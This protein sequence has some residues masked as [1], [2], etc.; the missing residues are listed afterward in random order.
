MCCWAAA[1]LALSCTLCALSQALDQLS[2]KWHEAAVTWGLPAIAAA[3]LALVSSPG[4]QVQLAALPVCCTASCVC[5][6]LGRPWC[7]SPLVR[8]TLPQVGARSNVR[9][10][11]WGLGSGPRVLQQLH[12]R[13]PRP[14]HPGDSLLCAGTQHAQGRVHSVLHAVSALRCYGGL[15]LCER[16]PEAMTLGAAGAASGLGAVMGL[17]VLRIGEDSPGTELRAHAVMRITRAG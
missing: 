8:V 3:V 12:Q 13:V 4:I 16:A 17:M 10:R 5:L 7:L 11:G 15:V 6:L 2:W 14:A 1:L 9:D